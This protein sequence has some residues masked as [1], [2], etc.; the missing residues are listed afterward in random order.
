MI[1]NSTI[2]FV[3]DNIEMQEYMNL[4][5]EDRCKELLFARNGEEGIAEWSKH[6]PDLIITDLNMPLM[7]GLEMSK[8]IKQQKYD[9]P[10]LLLTAYGDS[11]E[12]KEAINIGING[13]ISKPIESIS[14]LFETIENLLKKSIKN[15]K[16]IHNNT[17]DEQNHASFVNS[18]MYDNN[19]YFDYDMLRNDI[20]ERKSE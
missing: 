16:T 2:L 18:I 14:I 1:K 6:R 20:K 19:E 12:L 11:K 3:E 9:L 4:L 10:I 17:I 7:N 8:E 15:D 5:L 13:F